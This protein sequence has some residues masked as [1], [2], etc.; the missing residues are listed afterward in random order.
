[1]RFRRYIFEQNEADKQSG[2]DDNNS[3]GGGRGSTRWLLHTQLK[4]NKHE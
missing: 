4:S 3:G 2:D 1:M